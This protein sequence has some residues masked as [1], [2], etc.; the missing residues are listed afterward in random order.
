MCAASAS[1]TPPDGSSA[2]TAT[3]LQEHRTRHPAAGAGAGRAAAAGQGAR[4]ILLPGPRCASRLAAGGQPGRLTTGLEPC[5][6]L[7]AGHASEALD[8]GRI[9]CGPLQTNCAPGVLEDWLVLAEE[10]FGVPWS[11]ASLHLFWTEDSPNSP[12][13]SMRAT[14]PEDLRRPADPAGS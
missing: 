14:P 6:P 13:F 4:A 9:P 12:S 3:A 10:Y 7:Q 2:S 1:R 11:L 5:G 8:T